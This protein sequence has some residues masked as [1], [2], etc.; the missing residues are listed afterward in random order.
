[1]KTN[2]AVTPPAVIDE[3][4]EGRRF[5]EAETA[6]AEKMAEKNALVECWKHDSEALRNV[7]QLIVSDRRFSWEI[8]HAVLDKHDMLLVD[9]APELKKAEAARAAAQDIALPDW[10]SWKSLSLETKL[11]IIDIYNADLDARTP[12]PHNSK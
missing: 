6:K 7:V 11:R 1:M 5:W 4:E 8:T 12:P 9:K 2:K 10:A 3:I